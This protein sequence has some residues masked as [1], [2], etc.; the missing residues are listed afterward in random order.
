MGRCSENL[1]ECASSSAYLGRWVK[2]AK[3]HPEGAP[4]I[5]TVW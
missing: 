2:H 5:R 1:V 4:E 3:R